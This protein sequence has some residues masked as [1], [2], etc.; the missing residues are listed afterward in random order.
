MSQRVIGTESFG[1][2]AAADAA[3]DIVL[4][5][6]D[7]VPQRHDGTLVV[8]VAC[9]HGHIGHGGIGVGS[10]HRVSHCFVLLSD[11]HVALVVFAAVVAAVE[12]EFGQRDVL[13]ALARCLPPY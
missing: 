2:L 7:V 5:I 1:C 13:V 12:Q 9:F 11:R 10:A 3:C 6:D 4:A 8:D